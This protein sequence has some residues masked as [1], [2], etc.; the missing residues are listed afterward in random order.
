[1]YDVYLNNKFVGKGQ[2]Q[3]IG[4]AYFVYTEAGYKVVIVDE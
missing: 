3:Y 1:M 4:T 2:S